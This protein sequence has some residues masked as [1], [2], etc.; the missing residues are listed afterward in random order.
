MWICGLVGVE[1]GGGVG[2]GLTQRD[3]CVVRRFDDLFLAVQI[4][5]LH[6]FN[7]IPMLWER[8]DL[9]IDVVG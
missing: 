9:S 4:Q 7:E 1:L 3:L 5:E 8:G 2:E 6:I